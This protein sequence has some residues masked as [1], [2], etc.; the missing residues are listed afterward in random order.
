MSTKETR[1]RLEQVGLANAALEAEEIE[2]KP[3]SSRLFAMLHV[4]RS[5]RRFCNRERDQSGWR[6]CMGKPVLGEVAWGRRYPNLPPPLVRRT[7]RSRSQTG[8]S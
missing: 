5:T 8:C 3:S 6:T 4:L 2:G 7:S 1:L